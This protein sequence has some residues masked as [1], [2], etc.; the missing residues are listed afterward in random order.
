GR[1][2]SIT[3]VFEIAFMMGLGYLTGRILDW[4][5]MDSIFLGGILAISSTTIIVRAVDELG[6]RG[7]R[8][9]SLVFG[10][11]IVEDL[12]AILLLVLLSTIAATQ[13][14]AGGA[15]LL[16]GLKLGFFL[17]LWFAVGIYLVPLFLRRA[18]RYLN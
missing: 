4:S 18:H 1:P 5:R 7:R 8:F 3:A 10:V 11:L 9:V 16:A 17:L 15:L 12:I 14:L 2:A 13:A 6:M